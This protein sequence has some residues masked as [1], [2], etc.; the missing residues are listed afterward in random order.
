MPDRSDTDQIEPLNYGRRQAEP[1]THHDTGLP[2]WTLAAAAIVAIAAAL[3]L[4][5]LGTQD[6]ETAGPPT[7]P[8]PLD[9]PERPRPEP[10]PPRGRITDSTGAWSPIDPPPG[11]TQVT[12][13]DRGLLAVATLEDATPTLWWSPTG[14]TW[15]ELAQAPD[16]TERLDIIDGLVIAG[17]D[18]DLLAVLSPS[19]E[20]W[21]RLPPSTIEPGVRRTVQAATRHTDGSL[22]LVVEHSN[23]FD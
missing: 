21:R 11:T 14:T 9:Q 23:R 6:P 12:A 19:T 8:A 18:P 15:S 13:S 3:A 17:S 16:G 4:L 22:W 1:D 7:T 10:D 5:A 20:T 2:Q